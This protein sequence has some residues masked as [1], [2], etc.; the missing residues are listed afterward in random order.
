ML[1]AYSN[2]YNVNSLSDKSVSQFIS[3]VKD[4]PVSHNYLLIA[5]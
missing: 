2:I 4:Q 1:Q 3:H 5:N